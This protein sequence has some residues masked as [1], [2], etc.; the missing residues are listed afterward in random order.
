MS[1]SPAE[2]KAELERKKARLAALREEKKKRG[3]AEQWSPANPNEVG[4]VRA[5]GKQGVGIK[6]P[7]LVEL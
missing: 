3:G 6:L 4:D 5:D 2:R 1:A 7:N